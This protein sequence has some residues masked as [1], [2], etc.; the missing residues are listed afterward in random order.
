MRSIIFALAVA[1]FA[2]GAASQTTRPSGDAWPL[3]ERASAHIAEGYRM[4]IECPAAARGAGT[5]PAYLSRCRM[6][7]SEVSDAAMYQHLQG[8][9]AQ[10][11]ELVRDDLHLAELMDSM[12]DQGISQAL[13]AGGVRASGLNR[14][15]AMTTQIVLG[16]DPADHKSLQVSAAKALIGELFTTG[17]S[18]ARFEKGLRRGNFPELD[19]SRYDAFRTRLRR[20]QTERKLAAMSLA[21]HLY[22]FEKA[23]WPAS[24]A[25]LKPSLPGP[26]TDA[27]GP[28]GYALIKGRLPDRSDRPLV[29]SRYNAKDGLFYRLDWPEYGL[30]F[31]DGT[32]RR[33]NEQKQGGQF[34][35]VALWNPPAAKNG[36]ITRPLK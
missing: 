27:W 23:R 22:R 33:N 30:Y 26:L 4:G 20:I 12:P 14:L 3:Y 16:T 9:D 28:L 35:D 24:L 10:A 6:I 7:A 15:E 19:P 8:N 18:A 36:P 2:S 11:I 13:T 25:D 34:R 31:G 21:C 32:G 1:T 29:Y 17:D 5:E